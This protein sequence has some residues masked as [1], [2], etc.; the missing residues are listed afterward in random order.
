MFV[1]ILD[2]MN[3]ARVEYYFAEFLSLME[4]PSNSRYLEIISSTSIH[5]PVKMK[6][7]QIKLPDNI[8]F[9]MVNF[10][11]IIGGKKI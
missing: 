9:S 7:G 1:T 10:L 11:L 8:W 3:I 4:I 5:D 6:N 2:E